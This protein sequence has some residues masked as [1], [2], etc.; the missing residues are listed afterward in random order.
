M[1]NAANVKFESETVIRTVADPAARVAVIVINWN[2]WRLSLAC[3]KSLRA[4]NN[5]SWHLFLVDNA[6]TDDSRAHLVDLGDDVT[7]ILSETNGGW[8]GGNNLGIERALADGFDMF[9]ILNNDAVVTSETLSVLAR[10][11]AGQAKSPVL[12]PIQLDGEGANL[13]FIGAYI[14]PKSGMPEMKVV[15]GVDRS[16]LPRVYPTAFIRGAGLFARREHFD[17]VGL[18]D[19]RYYLNYD[20]SDWCFR[21]RA[22][23]Y[24]VLMLNDAEIFHIGSASIG[25]GLSPLNVYFVARNSLLFAKT[26]CTPLQR[27]NHAYLLTQWAARLTPETSRFPRLRAL[28]FGRSKLAIAWRHGVR[29]H[30]LARYGNCPDAIREI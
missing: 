8:T 19:N 13:D 16:Q 30:F 21:V 5:V 2:G 1:V 4:T 28:A 10:Y 29:D 11:C 17:S 15:E 3:L 23:G 27:L 7:V 9:F 25:G 6:S 22:K 24:D 20:E 14:D 26:H 18:F 12:G